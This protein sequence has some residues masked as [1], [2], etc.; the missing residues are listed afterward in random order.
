M[1][2]DDKAALEAAG[3]ELV[4][5]IT[6]SQK[7]L[8]ALT[9]PDGIRTGDLIVRRRPPAPVESEC[10]RMYGAAVFAYLGNDRA[11]EFKVNQFRAALAREI[12]AAEQRGFDRGYAVRDDAH[13]RAMERHQ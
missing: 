6:D 1:T 12:E 7:V 5:R 2:T 11:A 8:D 13:E 10:V 3:L 4:G 9:V